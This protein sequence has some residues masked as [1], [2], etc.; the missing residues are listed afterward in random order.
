MKKSKVRSM[1]FVYLFFIQQHLKVERSRF[2]LPRTKYNNEAIQ[3]FRINCPLS[4]L[5]SLSQGYFLVSVAVHVAQFVHNRQH[6]LLPDV[7]Q[8]FSEVRKSTHPWVD[9][10]HRTDNSHQ[11]FINNEPVRAKTLNNRCSADVLIIESKIHGIY[12]VNDA[13]FW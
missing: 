5:P 1:G 9:D 4:I 12:I 11:T 3:I 10:C 13:N 8:G 6:M 7:F 2:Y